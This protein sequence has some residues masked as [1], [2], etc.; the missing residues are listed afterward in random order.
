MSISNGSGYP[1]PFKPGQKSI[2]SGMLN[3]MWGSMRSNEPGIHHSGLLARKTPGGTLIDPSTGGR[4]QPLILPPFWVSFEK[5]NKLSVKPGTVNNIM[6]T[7]NGKALDEVPAP[8][9]DMPTGSSSEFMVVVKCTGEKFKRFP[10]DATIEV[11]TSTMA[12]ND[13]DA[14]GYLAIASL[15]KITSGTESVRWELNQLVSASVWADRRKLT[16][17]QTA[18]YYFS[19]V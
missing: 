1:G 3:R 9:L 12:R 11:V 15:R 7:I 5:D 16:E 8:K 19:R 17:P 10:L 18:F 13:T 14:Y 2:D 4:R 6:P